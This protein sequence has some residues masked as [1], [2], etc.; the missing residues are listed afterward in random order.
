MMKKVWVLF[1]VVFMMPF[2]AV[3]AETIS[4]VDRFYNL[5]IFIRFADETTYEAPF[6][7]DHYVELMNGDGPS[8]KDYYL[9]VSYDQLTIDSKFALDET[10][11]VFYTDIY[12]RSYFEPY[13]EI[14]NP[15]GYTSNQ[16]Y[17][18]EQGLLARAVEYA[19]SE[20]WFRDDLNYDRN[21]DGEIDS[22]TFMVSGEDTGWNTLLWPHKF[23][24]IYDSADLYGDAVGTYTFNLL[25]NS[26]TYPYQANLGI[27]AHETFHLLGAPD[28]YHYY[29][30]TSIE[31]V[32]DWG[33]MDN[34][35]DIPSHM[36]GYLK[37]D[38]A[39]WIESVETITESG[40]YTLYPLQ[41]NPNN[42]YRIE[43]AYPNEY[44]YLEYRDSDGLYESNLPSSGLLVYRVNEHY[45]G[46][47]EATYANDISDDEIFVFRP[48]VED[49]D[50]PITFIDDYSVDGVLEDAAL[51]QYNVFNSANVD[52]A[53][54]FYSSE[55]HHYDFYIYDVEEHD[56]HLTFFVSFDALENIIQPVLNLDVSLS[57][58]HT[59]IVL[60]D[61]PGT[62][63]TVSLPNVEATQTVYY[64]T[65]G[66]MPTDSSLIYTPGDDI[67]ITSDN[68][69]LRV[70]VYEGDVLLTHFEKTYTFASTIE[71]SHY[72]YG[73]DAHITWVAQFIE[74]TTTNMT[75]DHN[76][77]VEEA[78]DFIHVMNDSYT[79]T[80]LQN[81]TLNQ[82]N[83][84]L[85]VELISDE[86]LSNYYGVTATIDVVNPFEALMNGDAIMDVALDA[87]FNDP[88]ITLPD[89]TTNDYTI[90]TESTV[91]TSELGTYV[92]TYQV[93]QND[94][95]LIDTFTREVNVLDMTPPT[96]SLA[97]GIDTLVEGD[98]WKD[99]GVYAFD[100]VDDDLLI[101]KEFN[102]DTTPG[103][104]TVT[105]IVTDQSNNTTTLT[106]TITVVA[107]QVP[108][109]FMCD[110]TIQ[111]IDSNTVFERPDCYVN[112]TL[113]TP[114]NDINTALTGVQT[115]LYETTINGMS[116]TYRLYFFVIGDTPQKEAIIEKRWF[117]VY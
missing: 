40:E 91:D 110:E 57:N 11:V 59:E 80:E 104:Y 48:Y 22:I 88:G 85:M 42:M 13:D 55:G 20:G 14:N 94:H 101:T 50:P 106:R 72:G 49:I 115:I 70:V 60:L 26:Q 39:G 86:S 10:D 56:G 21:R 112:D 117:D 97:P 47:A 41:D 18:R 54:M 61:L 35:G 114:Q 58:P 74:A 27:L 109:T 99:A 3:N 51:S 84:T 19:E 62:L 103:T 100:D 78:Y 2:S 113:M 1:A 17:K 83:N 30:H 82:T 37:Y 95:I 66:S 52:D 108:L 5:V 105:Y 36:L 16:E 23:E 28:L 31:P 7:I 64:T 71:S 32:G 107:Q 34:E 4:N 90:H 25:G 116:V 75:F 15:N 102:V 73:D 45:E 87:L 77:Y 67:K 63:Y 92:V 9:E 29:N 38:Y 46:N 8:L 96:V 93:Y 43:T 24:M 76:T 68:N 44:V 6:G 65:D 12:E 98:V 81:V 111:T 33:L 53:F 89:S 69:I 79:G